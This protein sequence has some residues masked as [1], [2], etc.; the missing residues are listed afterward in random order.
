MVISVWTVCIL[1]GKMEIVNLGIFAYY[2]NDTLSELL[3]GIIC[4]FSSH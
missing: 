1:T 3:L 4:I 2:F